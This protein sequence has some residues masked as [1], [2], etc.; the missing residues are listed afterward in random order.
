RDLAQAR[1]AHNVA[2]AQAAYQQAIA[3]GQK[4]LAGKNYP[5]AIKSF[6]EALKI[7]PGDPQAGQFLK[8]S[9]A[10][11]QAAKGAEASALRHQQLIQQGQALINMKKYTE[12]TVP[13]QEALK[14]NPQ[15]PTAAAL[16]RQAQ[17]GLAEQNAQ[18]QA[19]AQEQKK[20]ATYADILK[21][22]QNL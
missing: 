5:E 18:A 11:W 22:G 4:S 7:Q 16:M 19:Q 3:L 17:A 10:A 12:A 9:E 21:T 15:D 2:Q 1:Q 20:K 13:L 8:Q 6:Q 14:M